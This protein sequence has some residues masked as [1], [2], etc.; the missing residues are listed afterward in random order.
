MV[1]L[2][3][4]LLPSIISDFSTG[5]NI[6]PRNKVVY[7][8]SYIFCTACKSQSTSVTCQRMS[9]R[10]MNK[11]ITRESLLLWAIALFTQTDQHA[12]WH[13]QNSSQSILKHAVIQVHT[14]VHLLML[15]II[16]KHTSSHVLAQVHG[17]QK[18]N[19]WV[20]RAVKEIGMLIYFTRK[21]ICIKAI[22]FLRLEKVRGPCFLLWVTNH[23]YCKF[24]YA[25]LMLFRMG[26][27]YIM[28]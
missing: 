12:I 15:I 27:P 22:Q 10:H 4:K 14:V 20:L 11:Q 24:Q 9:N 6:N 7:L 28:N 21:H 13:K 23:N 18:M 8:N 3:E 16:E 25:Q 17:V 2:L 5:P 1:I 19:F 26:T